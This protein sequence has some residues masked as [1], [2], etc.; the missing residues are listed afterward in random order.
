MNIQSQ[1]NYCYDKMIV[2]PNCYF[3]S[4]CHLSAQFSSTA[5]VPSVCGN[6]KL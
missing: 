5:N 6:I 1:N 4:L 3:S 2:L